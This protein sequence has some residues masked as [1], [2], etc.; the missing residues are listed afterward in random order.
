MEIGRPLSPADL[1]KQMANVML[2]KTDVPDTTDMTTDVVS[3]HEIDAYINSTDMTKILHKLVSAGIYLNIEG[4]NEV[5]RQSKRGKR[6]KPKG[7][8]ITYTK[9]SG[10]PSVYKISE[11]VEKL[12]ALMSKPEASDRLRKA[13]VESG[14]EFK[15]QKF[16]LQALYYA[17]KDDQSVAEKLL[18]MIISPDFIKTSKFKEFQKLFWSFDENQLDE[19]TT[20]CGRII[21]EK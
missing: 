21:G 18:R 8:D 4:K 5:R 7:S 10:R 6:G 16:L 9:Q 11:R 17:A 19:V 2:D 3:A 13:L 15:V 1:N 12:R 14:L 20:T